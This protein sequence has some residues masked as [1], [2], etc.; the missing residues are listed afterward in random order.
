M[1]KEI[2]P[3]EN[4]ISSNSLTT[5]HALLWLL[6]LS[7]VAVGA[8]NFEDGMAIDAHTYAMLARRIAQTGEWFHLQG[9]TP[10]FKIFAEHPH[11][12]FWLLAFIFK[13][14]PSAD[15]AG[16]ILAH[17]FYFGFMAVFFNYLR[18]ISGL[19]TAVAS[20][21]LLWSWGRFSNFFSIYLDPGCLFFG[22]TAIVC[23]DRGFARTGQKGLLSLM[24]LLA[25][26]CLALSLMYKGLTALGFVPAIFLLIPLNFKRE[27]LLPILGCL[28]SFIIGCSMV[29]LIYF[30]AVRNSSVPE[31]FEIYWQR[32]WI[33]RFSR[34]LNWT[35]IFSYLFWIKLWQDTNY[36][37][38]LCL[39][40]VFKFG[41]SSR[42]IVPWVLLSSF[43][44]MYA[45]NDRI[46]VNYWIT[47]LPWL[48]WIIADS[49]A[50]ALSWNPENWVR[51]T[52]GIS[53]I[54]IMLVQYV[55]VRVHGVPS[56]DLGSIAKLKK[57][58]R[59]D[60]LVVD[61]APEPIDF[62]VTD[63]YSWYSNLP[64]SFL[65]RT[66]RVETPEQG[67]LHI[68][69]K[70]SSIRITEIKKAGWCLYETYNNLSLWIGC[71]A[72][73]VQ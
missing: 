61:L 65:D 52:G 9:T 72:R 54:I 17:L 29:L 21:L 68:L 16:R 6:C 23:L 67:V 60:R 53:V 70:N 55:P 38:P 49:I 5:P 73:F 34:T 20:V 44:A 1:T 22:F 47:V 41:K 42:I 64:I 48:A 37:A 58:K 43:V 33:N 62:T 51:W 8:K 12:G 28:A 36:L 26:V 7:F 50:S 59:I 32:Q 13:V 10:E 14:L 69:Y 2:S 27:R 4:Q 24:S 66:S 71:P 45:T 15:W 30:I 31:F 19:K 40:A 39:L 63:Y 3:N 25:G 57:E 46:G 18:L 56:A 11:L 35:H